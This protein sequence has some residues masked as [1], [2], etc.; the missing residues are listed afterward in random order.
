MDLTWLYLTKKT[1]RG[2]VKG[3]LYPPRRINRLAAIIYALQRLYRR[4]EPSHGP[5]I[6][7]HKY[8]RRRMPSTIRRSRKTGR[9][10]KCPC[11]SG[12]KFKN[13]HLER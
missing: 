11:G 3:L 13:C 1:R 5:L 12:K 7:R 4:P 6:S 10:D 9:N 8:G 2:F